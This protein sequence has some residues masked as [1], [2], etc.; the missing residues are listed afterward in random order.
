MFIYHPNLSGRMLVVGLWLTDAEPRLQTCI[1]LRSS[2]ADP[3][4]TQERQS[5]LRLL[6][7]LPWQLGQ[8]IPQSGHLTTE[9]GATL[10]L[11]LLCFH[12]LVVQKGALHSSSGIR[13]QTL[14]VLDTC[15]YLTYNQLHSYVTRRKQ[16]VDGLLGGNSF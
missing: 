7:Q 5:Y 13:F 16:D 11:Y 15:L 2:S 14:K 3:R 1:S 12:S 8:T 9:G 4:Q 6:R 10:S